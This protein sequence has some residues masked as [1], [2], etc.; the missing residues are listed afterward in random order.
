[1]VHVEFNGSLKAAFCDVYANLD[2]AMGTQTLGPN[3]LNMPLKGFW[4]RVLFALRH[5]AESLLSPM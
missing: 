1:M 5:K 4:I 3:I 2:Q